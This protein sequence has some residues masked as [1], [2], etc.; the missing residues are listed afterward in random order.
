VIWKP[1]RFDGN[2]FVALEHKPNEAVISALTRQ[3]VL[4]IV[5]PRLGC[6]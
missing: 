4:V 2:K 3:Y 5:F 6:R 1:I